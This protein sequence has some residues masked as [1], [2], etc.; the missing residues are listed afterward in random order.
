MV[1]LLCGACRK[2]QESLEQGQYDEEQESK[3]SGRTTGALERVLVTRSTVGASD[4]AG[5]NQC[6]STGTRGCSRSGFEGFALCCTL[7]LDVVTGRGLCW[8]GRG[9]CRCRRRGWG[10]YVCCNDL[11]VRRIDAIRDIKESILRPG[12]VHRILIPCR[13]GRRDN[14]IRD[15]KCHT[16]RRRARGHQQLEPVL[17]NRNGSTTSKDSSRGDAEGD[18]EETG[19]GGCVGLGGVGGYNGDEAWLAGGPAGCGG[20]VLEGVAAGRSCVRG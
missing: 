6:S 8:C 3:C 4:D 2:I 18:G 16:P 11:E 5:D 10:C 9:S 15:R 20:G 12:K 17:D 1:L 7:F 13:Q 14:P 19:G